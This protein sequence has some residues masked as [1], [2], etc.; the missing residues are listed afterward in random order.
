M[1]KHTID[2]LESVEFDGSDERQN[3]NQ[4]HRKLLFHDV[5]N[6]LS[7]LKNNIGYMVDSHTSIQEFVR[8]VH[9]ISSRIQSS[10]NVQ[11]EWREAEKLLLEMCGQKQQLVV[12]EETQLALQDC[13]HD[14]ERIEELLM[15]LEK[16]G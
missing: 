3:I 15:S 4:R 6:S 16:I 7:V 14:I 13:Q 9:A 2:V 11:K 8:K 5:R 10:S 12:V 1:K